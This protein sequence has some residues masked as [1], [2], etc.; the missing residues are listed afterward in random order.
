MV[1]LGE[2]ENRTALSPGRLAAN[3]ARLGGRVAALVCTR[4]TVGNK[5]DP[6]GDVSER[7][8]LAST[9]VALGGSCET[10]PI[11]YYVSVLYKFGER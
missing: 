3:V 10:K 2:R 6:R 9:T 5:A 7:P 1:L 11:R 4:A 8:K